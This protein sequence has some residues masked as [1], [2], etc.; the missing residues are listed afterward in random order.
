MRKVKL[1]RLSNILNL[2]FSRIQNLRSFFSNAQ[3]SK[4]PVINK[5]VKY[6][7]DLVKDYTDVLKE[8]CEHCKKHPVKSSLIFVLFG[9]TYVCIEK[10]PDENSYR[11]CVINYSNDVLLVAK[12]VRNPNLDQFLTSLETC[13]NSG[14]LRRLNF[15]VGSIIWID[16][17][18]KELG[19]YK[20]NCKY[21]K[22]QISSFNQRIV[23]IGFLG[24]WWRINSYIKDYDVNADEW[25]TSDK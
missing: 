21:L 7:E 20:R 2:Q 22:P 5:W 25:E 17:Q 24:K 23:D 3:E 10:N 13:Y 9:F 18:S 4:T 15:G 19:L 14:I 6:W 8:T 16:D 1:V 12:T 11:D